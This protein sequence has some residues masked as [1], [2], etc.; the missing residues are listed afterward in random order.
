MTKTEKVALL[1]AHCQATGG[2]EDALMT[3]LSYV[4][5]GIDQKFLDW[6]VY[7]DWYNTNYGEEN[8]PEY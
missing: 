2:D 8:G 6:S 5:N 4:I 1:L 3:N 7:L